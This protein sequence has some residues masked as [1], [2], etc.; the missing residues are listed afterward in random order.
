MKLII[1]ALIVFVTI[2]GCSGSIGTSR[3]A[4]GTAD[5]KAQGLRYFLP[6]RVE[7]H[8]YQV[9]LPET[10]DPN[11]PM[12]HRIDRI[13]DIIT[14]T[15]NDPEALWQVTYRGAL[16]A[17]QSVTLTLNDKGAVKTIGLESKTGSTPVAVGA[18]QAVQKGL[19]TQ[20]SFE[21]TREQARID[22]L[23]RQTNLIKAKQNLENALAGK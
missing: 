3:I 15:I 23:N 6:Q 9:T 19:E 8:V 17:N 14:D 16:F 5:A 7:V 1:M 20:G 21:K 10:L 11:A 22:D 18:L 2:T 4:D 13:G 12:K